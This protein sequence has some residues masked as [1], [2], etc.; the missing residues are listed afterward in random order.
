MNNPNFKKTID[1]TVQ[2][3]I[4]NQLNG[5]ATDLLLSDTNVGSVERH[6]LLEERISKES[7]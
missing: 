7:T 3:V 4:I 1:I 6:L 5:V 2:S